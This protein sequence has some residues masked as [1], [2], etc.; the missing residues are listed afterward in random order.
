MSLVSITVDD[1]H[2][3]EA[4]VALDVLITQYETDL[5]SAV[6][7]TRWHARC[8]ERIEKAQAAKDA[9]S[10]QTFGVRGRL[11]ATA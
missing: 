7:G 1:D 8:V 2:V 4:L 6:D 5:G 3:L 9:L 11:A 10:V